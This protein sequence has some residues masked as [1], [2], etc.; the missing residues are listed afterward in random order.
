MNGDG[1]D[2]VVGTW[3]GS[4]VWYR[5]SLSG[6]WVLLS[7]AADMVAV[8]D[9]DGDGTNDLIGTWSSGLWV[10][11][12]STGSWDKISTALPEDIAAGD[13]NGDG[14]DD[15][16][17]TWSSGVYYKDSVSGN[18][19]SM[20]LSPATLLAAGNIDGDSANDLIGVWNYGLW[21]KHSS[22]MSWE[23][24]TSSLPGDIDAGLFRTGAW[25]IGSIVNHEPIGGYAEGPGIGV[26]ADLSNKA[27]GSWNFVIQEGRSLIPHEMNVQ[28]NRK[29]GPDE[30]GFVYTEQENLFPEENTH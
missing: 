23:K 24:L 13:M 26:F 5:D 20:S 29:P 1:R 10:L 2:D 12:S 25:D 9:I 8:G 18:W 3:T 6:S 11:Y 19:I 15:V 7:S 16:L 30:P 4:G 21:V 14:R 28:K 22:S 27:P 17:G